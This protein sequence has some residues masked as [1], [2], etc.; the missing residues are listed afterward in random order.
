MAAADKHTAVDLYGATP[1]LHRPIKT[2]FAGW[3]ELVLSD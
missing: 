1:L 2:P 3:V